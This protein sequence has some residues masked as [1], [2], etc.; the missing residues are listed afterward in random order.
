MRMGPR[1]EHSNGPPH[2]RPSYTQR[3]ST[4][5]QQNDQAQP[6]SIY[7][8][9]ELTDVSPSTSILVIGESWR[10]IRYGLQFDRKHKQRMVLEKESLSILRQ[11]YTSKHELDLALF[12]LRS[13]QTKT[14]LAEDMLG[15]AKAGKL[16]IDYP[17]HLSAAWNED[18]AMY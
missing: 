4:Y 7:N 17:S 11:T 5:N 18:V 15:L 13:A 10:L 6:E 9:A 1:T 14:K 3:E 2:G 12:D 8:A 16:G